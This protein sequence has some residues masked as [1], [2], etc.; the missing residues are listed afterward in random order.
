MYQ[1]CAIYLKGRNGGNSHCDIIEERKK[2]ATMKIYLNRYLK[3][4]YLKSI[5]II[6]Y[7]FICR[8]SFQ[9]WFE[10]F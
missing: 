4:Y 7:N 3:I 5:R 10:F 6:G 2:K 8:Y 1:S 9:N